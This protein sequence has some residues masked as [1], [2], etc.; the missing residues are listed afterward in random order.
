MLQLVDDNVSVY[1]TKKGVAELEKIT[2]EKFKEM[3]GLIPD[4]NERFKRI[5]GG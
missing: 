3:Y 1:L 5:N 2:P 4:Q